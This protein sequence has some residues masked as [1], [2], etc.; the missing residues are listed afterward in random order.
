VDGRL[1][2]SKAGW[3]PINRGGW[4][5][6]TASVNALAEADDVDATASV[7]RY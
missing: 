2:Y 1:G 6:A 7:N 5:I 3:L 4:L